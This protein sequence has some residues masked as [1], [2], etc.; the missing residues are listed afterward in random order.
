[1]NTFYLFCGAVFC[2]IATGVLAVWYWHQCGLMLKERKCMD[3]KIDDLLGAQRVLRE[4]A[5]EQG[6]QC[7][8]WF[9]QY[10]VANQK[11]EK[12]RQEVEDAVTAEKIA[13]TGYEKLRK[14]YDA[15][16]QNALAAQLRS[17][18]KL[19]KT[20]KAL[21]EAKAEAAVLAG[22]VDE[23]GGALKAWQRWACQVGSEKEME[24]L[25]D[26]GKRAVLE[27]EL[28]RLRRFSAAENGGVS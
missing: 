24:R 22:H 26:E 12:C 7:S 13:S 20:Q 6:D 2:Q 19:E 25:T 10:Q 21:D 8:R 23:M 16:D 3:R 27:R 28:E 5:K 18:G 17:A 14:E 15:L 4:N 1:M 9:Q 11:L